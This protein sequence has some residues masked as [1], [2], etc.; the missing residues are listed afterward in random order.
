MFNTHYT[1]IV[2]LHHVLI[3]SY[4]NRFSYII[5]WPYCWTIS[6]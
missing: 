3:S 6:M 4:T 2:S 1:S 5:H